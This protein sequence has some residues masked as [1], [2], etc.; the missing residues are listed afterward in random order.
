MSSCRANGQTAT[1]FGDYT[2]NPPLDK[3]LIHGDACE[4]LSKFCSITYCVHNAARCTKYCVGKVDEMSRQTRPTKTTA[5]AAA[6]GVLRGGGAVVTLSP[7]DPPAR[8]AEI[9]AAVT[10]A[11]LVTEEQF[12]DQARAAGFADDELVTGPNA[13]PGSV[14]QPVGKEHAE[15]QVEPDALAFLICTSGSSG[16][17]KI[18]MQTHRQNRV[19]AR[20]GFRLNSESFTCESLWLTCRN[21]RFWLA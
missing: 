3:G 11:V 18:V 16:R 14:S 8:L 17:P 19:M 10:P 13:A 9:R 12:L 20:A 2:R 1:G 4:K 6:L 15:A 5:L 21:V 7:T